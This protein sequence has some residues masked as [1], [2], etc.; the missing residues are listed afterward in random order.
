MNI[1]WSILE[2][3]VIIVYYQ[4]LKSSGIS[5]LMHISIASKQH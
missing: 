5:I 3:L 4:G 1:A 2:G